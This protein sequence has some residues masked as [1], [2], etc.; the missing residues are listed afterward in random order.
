MGYD[1]RKYDAPQ[2]R[3]WPKSRRSTDLVAASR[4]RASFHNSNQ[5]ARHELGKVIIAAAAPMAGT[6]K[7]RSIQ[8]FGATCRM[9]RPAA[10]PIG[11]FRFSIG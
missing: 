10:A 2:S 8:A 1:L 4:A 11:G 7:H 5:T 3:F 9:R 6:E